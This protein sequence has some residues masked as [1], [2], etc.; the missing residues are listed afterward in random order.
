MTAQLRITVVGKSAD[1]DEQRLSTQPKYGTEQV[2]VAMA[3]VRRQAKF[4]TAHKTIIVAPA[5]NVVP[6]VRKGDRG[7]R[8][9]WNFKGSGGCDT[10]VIIA[11][12]R[13]RTVGL[14]NRGEVCQGLRLRHA[15][16]KQK[17]G[18]EPVIRNGLLA[19][20]SRGVELLRN[21]VL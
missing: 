17:M 13:E 21:G 11:D 12:V 4:A 5:N 3:I 7:G 8:C 15:S 1:V 6:G 2:G 14:P 9:R 20:H 10:V 19:I 16:D 18:D